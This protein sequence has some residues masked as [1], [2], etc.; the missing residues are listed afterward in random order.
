MSYKIGLMIV[1][2]INIFNFKLFGYALDY[3]VMSCFVLYFLVKLS[4]PNYDRKF[5]LLFLFF[6]IGVNFSV[7]FSKDLV[8]ALS[9][10]VRFVPL[11]FFYLALSAL[12]ESEFNDLIK[13]FIYATF[14][15]SLI[16]LYHVFIGSY[17]YYG[18]FLFSVFGEAGDPNFTAYH[19]LIASFSSIYLSKN[20]RFM[21]FLFIFFLSLALLTISRGVFLSLAVTI[22]LC[23]K[24]F[25]SFFGKNNFTILILILLFFITPFLLV[26]ISFF[27]LNQKSG[28]F[29]TEGLGDGSGR[30]QVLQSVLSDFGDIFWT[31]IGAGQY[32]NNFSQIDIN[33]TE[34]KIVAHNS[35]IEIFVSGGIFLLISFVSIFYYAIYHKKYC[36]NLYNS[37]IIE[38]LTF[39]VYFSVLSMLSL[40]LE[41][42]RLMWFLVFSLVVLKNNNFL[43]YK[44]T[45]KA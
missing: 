32:M 1:L 33:G 41:P 35:Y 13:F 42:S 29:R 25:R 21:Y 6:V 16:S 39:F 36:V 11:V 12:K 7:F 38:L 8:S 27:D 10:S 5:M 14:L 23:F 24:Q 43:Y 44:L 20:N 4:L 40:N 45:N 28:F 9:Y 31:G 18:R 3:F 22:I 26:Y 37:K 17:T 34:I 15:L 19:L 30:L 2:F